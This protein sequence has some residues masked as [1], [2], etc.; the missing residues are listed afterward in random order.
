MD[1]TALLEEIRDELR[2]ANRW[3]RI[4]ATPLI[5]EKLRAILK[6]D[7]EWRVYRASDG[8]AR[9]QVAHSSAV[10]HGTVS[11]YW[12]AWASLGIVEETEVKG[13]FRKVFH[14]DGFVSGDDNGRNTGNGA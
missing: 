8:R 12:K 10:S 7:D 13:R 5:S 1:Q 2:Q 9:E 11:N 4:L 6:K 14:V 3:L